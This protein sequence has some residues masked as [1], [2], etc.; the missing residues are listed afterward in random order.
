MF[1][2]SEDLW[3]IPFK[4]SGQEQKDKVSESL[5]DNLEAQFEPQGQ[6]MLKYL[7]NYPDSPPLILTFFGFLL[8]YLSLLHFTLMHFYVCRNAVDRSTVTEEGFTG[9][10]CAADQNMLVEC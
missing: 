9:V 5:H 2:L 6:K 10:H 4:W 8:P 7:K 1:L 3:G